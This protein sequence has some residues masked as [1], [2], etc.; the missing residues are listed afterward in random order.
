MLNQKPSIG[1][2]TNNYVGLLRLVFLIILRDLQNS[3]AL[4]AST[5][6]SHYHIVYIISNDI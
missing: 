1:V 6:C 2:Y 4:I 3:Q 5:N